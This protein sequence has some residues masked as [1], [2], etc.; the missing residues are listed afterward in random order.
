MR[1]AEQS[2]TRKSFYYEWWN[3]DTVKEKSAFG[4]ALFQSEFSVKVFQ[5]NFFILKQVKIFI[6]LLTHNS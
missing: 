3:I 4:K 6:V 2:E 5:G 1:H